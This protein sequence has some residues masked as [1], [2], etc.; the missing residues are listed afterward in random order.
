MQ[1]QG[2]RCQ[3]QSLALRGDLTGLMRRIHS[4]KVDHH[5]RAA[6]MSVSVTDNEPHQYLCVLYT[7]RE[8]EET[9][10]TTRITVLIQFQ[11]GPPNVQLL[12][13]ISQIPRPS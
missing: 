8:I 13:Q 9:D 6:L 10:A 12:R 2:V 1:C 11:L 7:R 5:K 4:S 3:D